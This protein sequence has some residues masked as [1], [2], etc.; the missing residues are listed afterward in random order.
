GQTAMANSEV[1]GAVP[2]EGQEMSTAG[3]LFGVVFSPGEAFAAIARKPG[4]VAPLVT[5]VISSV[6]LTESMLAKIG[7]AQIVRNS[8]VTSGRAKNMTPDQIDQ[9]VSQGAKFAA[10]LMRVIEVVGV[11]IF[12]LIVAAIALLIVNAIL[13]GEIKF[14]TAFSVVAYADIPAVLA[15]VIGIVMIFFGDL[16]HFD[17][18]NFLPTK[19]SFFMNPEQVSKPL[20]AFASSVDIFY[21]WFMILLGI[22]LS[23]ATGRKVKP[24]P[25]FLG[26]FTVWVLIAVVKVG[27]ALV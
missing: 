26:F 17:P 22:G 14:K 7:A 9:A 1:T 11:P 13:G 15:T 5:L 27:F 21:F 8:L 10:V 20:F 19:L 4:F 25:I 2:M 24:L 12:L 16:S 6:A 3:R 18:N 23:A